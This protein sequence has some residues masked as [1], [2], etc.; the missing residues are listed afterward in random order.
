MASSVTCGWIPLEVMN[1]DGQGWTGEVMG[2]GTGSV[3]AAE[4]SDE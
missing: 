3:E 4:A 1:N 2:M